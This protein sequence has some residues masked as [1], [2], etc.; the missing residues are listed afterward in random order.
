VAVVAV[1]A[2][3]TGGLVRHANLAELRQGKVEPRILRHAAAPQTTVEAL[4]QPQH[5]E[6]P[7]QILTEIP[8]LHTP[9]RA[10]F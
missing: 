1:E 10:A 2:G 9:A 8:H 5:H 4:P 3:M 6:G 7:A